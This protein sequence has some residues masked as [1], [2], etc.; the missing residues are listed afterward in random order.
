MGTLIAWHYPTKLFL[1][2]ADHT[3]VTCSNGAVRWGC[4]GGKTGGA[5]LRQRVGSTKRADKIAEP[6]ERAGITCYLIN[7]VCHQAA[8]RILYP[9]HITV[10]GARGYYVSESLYG[11][12]GRPRGFLGLCNAP[13]HKHHGVDGDLEPCAGREM[14]FDKADMEAIVNL[15]DEA[16]DDAAYKSYLERVNA[17]YTEPDMMALAGDSEQSKAFQEKLFESLIDYK[18]GSS[19]LSSKAG[20]HLMEIRSTTEDIRTPIES[21]LEAG[22]MNSTEFLEHYNKLTEQFQHDVGNLLDAEDYHKLLEMEPGDI[23]VLGDPDIIESAYGA[24]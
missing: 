19:F 9:A 20:A 22:E 7:G 14:L 23:V 24:Q 16:E 2:L 17:L 10:R 12:Y 6:D 1:N 15:G 18:L 5:A 8:N 3:Y 11:T 13:F 21:S 4:W